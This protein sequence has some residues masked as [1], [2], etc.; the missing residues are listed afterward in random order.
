MPQDKSSIR[1]YA[2]VFYIQHD[3]ARSGG[4][5]KGVQFPNRQ[6]LEAYYAG[7]Q[8]LGAY[9]RERPIQPAELDEAEKQFRTLYREMP[10]FV[11][12]LMLLGLTLSEKRNEDEA[13]IIFKLAEQVL[14]QKKEK[15]G[16]LKP[17]DRKVLFQAMLFHATAQRKLY[18]LQTNSQALKELK[19]LQ[20]DILPL[21]PVPPNVPETAD[22]LD[23]LKIYIS[24]RVEEAY[25]NA[26]DLILLSDKHSLEKNDDDVFKTQIQQRYAAHR[27]AVEDAEY[28]IKQ[29]IDAKD[30]DGKRVQERFLSD[31]HN[32]EGYARYRRAMILEEDDKKFLQECEEARSK[33]H[34]AYA[35]HQ[36]EYTILLNLGLVYADPRCDPENKYIE[37]ARHFLKQSIEI[38]PLDYYGHELLARLAVRQAYTWG[39]EFIDPEIINEAAKSADTARKLRPIS[40]T[41]YALLAQVYTVQWAKSS[42]D[43]LRKELE[44]LIEA[45][46]LRA[47]RGDATPVHQATARTQWL[48]QQSRRAKGDE[49]K[50]LRLELATALDKAI[51]VATDDRSWYGKKLL[52]DANS[53]K[54]ALDDLG[55]KSQSILRW[56]S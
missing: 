7:R 40:G 41:L 46:L 31:L 50:A 51:E 13:L 55:G 26:V 25:A 11:D 42:D 18:Q 35:V 49:F 33:L 2:I 15:E 34:E 10:T 56:P 36:N 17:D 12:G 37:F 47:E 23:Y 28:R 48:F 30:S 27:S 39:L 16:P 29:Q 9:Q 21:L 22:K 1:R 8:H 19:Q 3:F 4:P 14:S 54:K 44:P 52:E 20:D 5:P 32:A 24:A 6:A 38:K 53:L 43:N 45:S